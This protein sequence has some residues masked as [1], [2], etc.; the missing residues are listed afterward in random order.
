MVS[1][2][3]AEWHKFAFYAECCY[4][5]C[6]YTE[7]HS[8]KSSRIFVEVT[9]IDFNRCFSIRYDDTEKSSI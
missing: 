9:Q 3:Y 4:A 5:G 1:V 7:C 6:Y 8:A 2:A